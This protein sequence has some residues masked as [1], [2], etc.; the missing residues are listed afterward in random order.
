MQ[1]SL[2]ST[3][4]IQALI[5]GADTLGN[6]P[7]VLEE[8]GIKIKRHIS[9]RLPAHQKHT[10]TLPTGVNVLILLTDFL[11]HNVMKGFRAQAE[12]AGIPVLAC[13]RSVSDL[14][15]C[16]TRNY[17]CSNTTQQCAQCP[18]RQKH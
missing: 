1:S 18:K 13:R 4:L 15:A 5:V 7:N 3:E 2:S 6:I 17:Q 14:R 9:G 8:F 10:Q 16:L 12:K 11:G